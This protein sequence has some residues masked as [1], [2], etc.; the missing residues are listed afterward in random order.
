MQSW[1]L[2]SHFPNDITSLI[3]WGF[4]LATANVDLFWKGLN[5][6]KQKHNDDSDSLTIEL[7]YDKQKY[8]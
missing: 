3:E 4:K 7:K 2:T 5:A 8:N 6:T 1:V